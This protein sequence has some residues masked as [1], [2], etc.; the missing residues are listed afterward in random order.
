MSSIQEKLSKFSQNYKFREVFSKRDASFVREG[1]KILNLQGQNLFRGKQVQGAPPT[2][3]GRKP[4]ISL[5]VSIILEVP[6]QN[7]E[8]NLTLL[9]TA[10]ESPIIT[11]YFN[12]K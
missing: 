3:C 6:E 1:H 7:F 11:C 5:I 8:S 2:P 4:D 10:A 9:L 12:N